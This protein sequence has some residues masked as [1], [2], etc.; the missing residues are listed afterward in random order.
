MHHVSN[1]LSGLFHKRT[2]LFIVE[3]AGE[4][5]HKSLIENDA[6]TQL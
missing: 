1:R 6:I 4:P 3:Q 5:V 2:Y